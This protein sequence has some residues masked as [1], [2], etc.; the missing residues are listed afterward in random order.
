MSSLRY[1]RSERLRPM[2]HWK[3]P[4]DVDRR[5][6]IGIGP[7]KDRIASEN[8]NGSFLSVVV[9]AKNE[10][11]SLSQ[12]VEEITRA[13][14]PLCRHRQGALEGFE[15]VVVDDASTDATRLILEDLAMLYPELRRLSLAIGVGQS[16]AT[17]AGICAAK[18]NWI[19]TLDADLQNDPVD[20]VRLW[21]A[22]P[23]HNSAVLGWRVRR[24]DVWTKRMISYWANMLR[25]KVLA[26]SIR[27]TGCSVRIFP[28]TLA[29]RLP[30]FHGMHRFF[31]SLL[32]REGCQLVQVP[33]HHRTRVHGRSHYNLWNR[34]LQVAI[35]LLGVAWLMNRPLR[36]QVIKTCGSDGPMRESEPPEMVDTVEV[37]VWH[38]YQE[39]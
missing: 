33:V 31:G 34:S 5:Q 16:A 17:M 24:Q 38:Y 28:R 9:P 1:D 3:Q 29:L 14:H 30:M 12:L 27:D 15:I 26:Q 21:R 2:G 36:C 35:D 25:N 13:L 32:L 39:D 4:V 20:L 19:A 18:G 22:L 10:A 37:P 6:T 23:G 7:V 8:A 11:A